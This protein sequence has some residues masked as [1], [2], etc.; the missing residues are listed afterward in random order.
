MT[1]NGKL[2]DEITKEI[3]NKIENGVSRKDAA[4]TSGICE[5]TFYNWIEKGKEAKTGKYL[6]FLQSI[7]KAESELKA[8]YEKI[9]FDNAPKDWRAG[10]TWLERKYSDEYGKKSEY[11][12][13]HSGK[14]DIELFKKYLEEKNE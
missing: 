7:K 11:K 14:V 9:I 6:Q 8:T 5:K 12:L 10:M 1:N 13:E 3:C 2:N 4:I